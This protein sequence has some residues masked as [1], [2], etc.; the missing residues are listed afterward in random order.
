MPRFKHITG[1]GN[2]QFTPEEEKARDAEELEFKK[3]QEEYLKVKY[4]DD[5]KRAYP[6]IGDQLDDLFKQGAFSKEM[7]AKLQQVKTDHPKPE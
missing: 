5:R 4:K 7:T 2:V 3:E 6:E 1:L